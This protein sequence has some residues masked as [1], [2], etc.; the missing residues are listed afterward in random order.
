MADTNN[1]SNSPGK[2]HGTSQY[3]TF[4]WKILPMDVKQ[5]L[6]SHK[7]RVLLFPNNSIIVNGFGRNPKPH[8]QREKPL[9]FMAF[10]K[11]CSNLIAGLPR[12]SST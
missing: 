7:G 4:L 10:R 8:S 9:D 5:A 1:T 12:A 11:A 2:L 6:E 3:S